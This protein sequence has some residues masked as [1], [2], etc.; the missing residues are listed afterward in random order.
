MDTLTA[1]SILKNQ[2]KNINDEIF[3]YVQNVVC[4]KVSAPDEVRWTYLNLSKD[5]LWITAKDRDMSQVHSEQ[6]KLPLKIR[7]GFSRIH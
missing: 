4:P 6:S 7:V 1:I 3:N 5:S 2:V